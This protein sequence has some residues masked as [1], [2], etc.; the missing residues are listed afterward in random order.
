VTLTWIVLATGIG[1]VLSVV[2]AAALTLAVLT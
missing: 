1:G 2:V